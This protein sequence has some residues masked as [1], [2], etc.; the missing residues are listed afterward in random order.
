MCSLTFC[1][2]HSLRRFLIRWTLDVWWW[3]LGHILIQAR[4]QGSPHRNAFPLKSQGSRW[5]SAILSQVSLQNSLLQFRR[6]RRNDRRLSWN[7]CFDITRRRHSK[8]LLLSWAELQ[9]ST[10]VQYWMELQCEVNLW[11]SKC[12]SQKPGISVYDLYLTWLGRFYSRQSSLMSARL[13]DRA[14]LSSRTLVF[15]PR[16]LLMKACCSLF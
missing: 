10:R 6:Q 7:K 15:C 8:C 9:W 5:Q 14:A 11:M 12:G 16:R 3:R 13:H 4:L 1:E 2:A